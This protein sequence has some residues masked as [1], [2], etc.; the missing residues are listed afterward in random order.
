VVAAFKAA[1]RIAA[2]AAKVEHEAMAAEQ[3]HA[4]LAEAVTCRSN[5]SQVLFTIPSLWDLPAADS[6]SAAPALDFG[7]ATLST[8]VYFGVSTLAVGDLQACYKAVSR[9]LDRLGAGRFKLGDVASGSAALLA[10]SL[11]PASREVGQVLTFMLNVPER[12]NAWLYSTKSGA[13]FPVSCALNLDSA[14]LLAALSNVIESPAPWQLTKSRSVCFWCGAP[15]IAR[16]VQLFECASCRRV[17]YCS[18]ECYNA[19]WKS[20]HAFE[21]SGRGGAEPP[22]LGMTRKLTEVDREQSLWITVAA[23]GRL[24]AECGVLQPGRLEP[25][26]PTTMFII[27]HCFRIWLGGDIC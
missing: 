12:C 13:C 5:A 24:K 1:H 21:C 16:G 2:V 23:K 7:S 19:D 11:P 4:P 27:Q 25:G 20:A 14:V 17:A 3:V 22:D 8:G 6:S 9:F 10:S 15:P 18:A 26:G